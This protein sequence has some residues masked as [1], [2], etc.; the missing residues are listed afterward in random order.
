M[1][2]SFSLL[3]D[4]PETTVQFKSF[5]QIEIPQTALIKIL[6]E[7][8]TIFSFCRC[9][10]PQVACS[11]SDLLKISIAWV[12]TVTG[13]WAPTISTQSMSKGGRIPSN[14]LRSPTIGV[15]PSKCLDIFPLDEPK[16]HSVTMTHMKAAFDPSILICDW[17][18][19][20][21]ARWKILLK[22]SQDE[23]RACFIL[24][25]STCKLLGGEGLIRFFCPFRSL[26]LSYYWL[27]ISIPFSSKL[28]MFGHDGLTWGHH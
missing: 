24:H 5:C 21:S 10:S 9:M 2:I 15:W 25:K 23:F 16:V 1:L 22:F 28:S 18:T 14:F 19:K 6:I 17:F 13:G 27:D 7:P 8:L 26:P 11:Y 3:L 12:E 20:L 4:G